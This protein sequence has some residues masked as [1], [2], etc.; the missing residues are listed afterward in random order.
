MCKTFC[1]KPSGKKQCY[2]CQYDACSEW[3]EYNYDK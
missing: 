2:G 1:G 3:D